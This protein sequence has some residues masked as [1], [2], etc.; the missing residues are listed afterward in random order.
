MSSGGSGTTK[1]T[2]VTNELLWFNPDEKASTNIIVNAIA[3]VTTNA[4][5]SID[6]ESQPRKRTADDIAADDT[7]EFATFYNRI[8]VGGVIT[9]D[10]DYRLRA[11]GT[12]TPTGYIGFGPNVK[13]NINVI[14]EKALTWVKSTIMRPS[15]SVSIL[16]VVKYTTDVKRCVGKV[17]EKFIIE[18]EKRHRSGRHNV[19]GRD[20][21]PMRP[22]I[23]IQ[24]DTQEAPTQLST[25]V[26]T[27]S[28]QIP[29]QLSTQLNTHN[30][31][32]LINHPIYGNL[33][34]TLAKRIAER[35]RAD[36]KAREERNKALETEISKK[37]NDM[38][39]ALKT[40]MSK[41]HNDM[42]SEMIRRIKS[43]E[44]EI[45]GKYRQEL[46]KN[47]EFIRGVTEQLRNEKSD[48]IRTIIDPHNTLAKWTDVEE[49]ALN[50]YGMVGNANANGS[51]N[52]NTGV[53]ASNGNASTVNVD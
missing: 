2:N 7:D 19:V 5:A 41:K 39:A 38:I 44:D 29:A 4:A 40:E 43:K 53:N 24:E 21:E 42:Q 12:S 22:K 35:D 36:I 15:A 37:R 27:L 1:N 3:D 18:N 49:A 50:M 47:P 16:Y 26:P 32:T 25:Q 13:G 20:M 8:K 31:E 52:A 17:V 11:S 33:Y 30:A 10:Y 28:T 9:V 48:E 45:V 23:S 14:N 46:L 6:A 34:T 51:V